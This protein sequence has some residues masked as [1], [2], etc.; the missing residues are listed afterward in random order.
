MQMAKQWG[1]NEGNFETLSI[2][3]IEITR[4]KINK[5]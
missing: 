3:E 5:E 2:E 4:E 1:M